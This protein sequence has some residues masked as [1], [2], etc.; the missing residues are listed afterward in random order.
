[1]CSRSVKMCQYEVKDLD[2]KQRQL[3]LRSRSK[4]FDT[5]TEQLKLC[6]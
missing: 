1:M 4:L 5:F 2:P 6:M 3:L